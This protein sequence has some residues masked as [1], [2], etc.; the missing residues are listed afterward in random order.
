MSKKLKVRKVYKEGE[1]EMAL[2]FKNFSLY[3]L[4]NCALFEGANHVY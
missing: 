2:N 1:A 3:K 4:L